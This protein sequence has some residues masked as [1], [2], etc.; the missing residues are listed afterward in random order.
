MEQLVSSNNGIGGQDR[1]RGSDD[2]ILERDAHSKRI[3]FCELGFVL[4]ECAVTGHISK[5]FV[6]LF[7]Y[8]FLGHWCRRASGVTES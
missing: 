4:P 2:L 5:V 8:A 1:T 7:I 6:A 3:T